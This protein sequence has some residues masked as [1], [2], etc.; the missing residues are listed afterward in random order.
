MK[1]TS[2]RDFEKKVEIVLKIVNLNSN[3]KSTTETLVKDE[4][5]V[6]M[7][8]TK[9]TDIYFPA[10]EFEK[11]FLKSIWRL[12]EKGLSKR[13][14]II[15]PKGTVEIIFNYSEDVFYNNPSLHVSKK[16]PIVFV[17][18]IN[19]KPFEL[20][21]TGQQNFLGIQLNGIGLR[22]L[23]NISAKEC[24][25]HVYDG[26]E[27]CSHLLILAEELSQIK[28]FKQQVET[29]LNWIKDRVV[30]R[31]PQY[32]INRAHLLLS[33]TD[34]G[35]TTVKKL[36]EAICLSDRQLRRFSTDW[37][38]MNTEQ[39]SHYQRYISC[40]HALHNSKRTLTEI[41]LQAGYYDQSHFIHEFKSYTN[42]SPKQYREANAEYP[43]HILLKD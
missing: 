25:N 29:I 41:G 20:I 13:R 3:C 6:K 22:L 31:C 17:N 21:K 30:R 32:S 38:G 5:H 4:I 7:F 26:S 40:L 19:F 23:F 2:Y 37:L 11:Y 28:I 27:M 16:L 39:L 36:S 43:G 12:S 1:A 34:I 42:M 33:L 18:G 24:N 9:T 10:E 8:V 15:L 35:D 14:E